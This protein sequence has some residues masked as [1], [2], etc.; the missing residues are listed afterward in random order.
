MGRDSDKRGLV[1]DS[2]RRE[3]QKSP[4]ETISPP[5]GVVRDCQTPKGGR[6]VHAPSASVVAPRGYPSAESNGQVEIESLTNLTEPS[7]I[8]TFRPEGWRLDAEKK[9]SMQALLEIFL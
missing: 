5:D 7:P 4:A 1:G 2:A 9:S 8:R 3:F 6:F